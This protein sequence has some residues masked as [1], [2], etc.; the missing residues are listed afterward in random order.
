M[1]AGKHI[2]GT[3][4]HDQVICEKYCKE[5]YNNLN[6]IEQTWRSLRYNTKCRVFDLVPID[7][8]KAS[9][10]AINKQI[11][12]RWIELKNNPEQYVYEVASATINKY[13]VEFELLFQAIEILGVKEIERLDHDDINMKAALIERSNHTA[14]AKLR[15]VLIDVFKLNERYSKKYIKDKL[16]ELY[17][18]LQVRNPEG[19]IKK[20]TA[21]QL[22]GYAL[23][24]IK[25]C[26]VQDKKGDPCNG[27][28]ITKVHY[29]LKQVA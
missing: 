8:G 20:A 26:K 15:L 10:K 4:F 29:T 6:S 17:N 11:V 1:N 19:E 2:Y 23:F 18:Q 3:N 9:V 14:E 28:I 13:K 5:H 25:D 12:E 27:F 16:Q 21:A 22:K 7:R 24:D